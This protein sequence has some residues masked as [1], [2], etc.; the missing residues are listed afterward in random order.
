MHFM[1]ISLFDM[2]SMNSQLSLEKKIVTKASLDHFL[3][4]NEITH[5]L[6][7]LKPFYDFMKTWCKLQ[8]KMHFLVVS[9]GHVNVS[10]NASNCFYDFQKISPERWESTKHITSAKWLIYALLQEKA[11]LEVKNDTNL[12]ENARFSTFFRNPKAL[13]KI[14]EIWVFW[15]IEKAP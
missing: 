3:I 15:S 1:I 9:R 2:K 8:K 5:D 12:H 4:K 6:A 14:H 10:Q 13:F 11:P 7:L